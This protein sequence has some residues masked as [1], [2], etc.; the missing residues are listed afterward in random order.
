[1]K[2]NALRFV[3]MLTLL[4]VCRAR[5][6]WIQELLGETGQRGGVA[7]WIGEG[8]PEA[9]TRAGRWS[10]HALRVDAGGVATPP[11]AAP[12]ISVARVP[13]L[14]RLPYPDHFAN[15]VIADTRAGHGLHPDELVRVTAPGGHTVLLRDGQRQVL[16]KPFPETMDGWPHWDY[17]AGANAVNRDAYLGLADGLR[18]TAGPSVVGGHEGDIGYRADGGRVVTVERGWMDQIHRGVR[19][20][21]ERLVARDGF[22]GALLWQIPLPENLRGFPNRVSVVMAGGRVITP[23][24]PGEAPVALDAATGEVLV[25]Y[26]EG[27]LLPLRATDG[28][29]WRAHPQVH[30]IQRVVNGRILQAGGRQV[31][32]LDLESGRRH[33]RWEAEDPVVWMASDGQRVL[34]VTSPDGPRE[35][36]GGFGFRVD[37]LWMLD[38]ETGRA[39]WQNRDFAGRGS[40]RL[41]FADGALY[42]PHFRLARE[43]DQVRGVQVPVGS[44]LPGYRQDWLVTS[45]DPATG[46]RRWQTSGER[47][48]A[49]HYQI[50]FARGEELFV[51][52]GEGFAV[53]TRDGSDLPSVHFGPFDGCAEP[54]A[55][56][57]WLFYTMSFTEFDA[58]R[59]RNAARNR[60]RGFARSTCDTGVFPVFGSVLTTPSHC[61]CND[62]P[63][64]YNAFAVMADP[65]PVP[66]DWRWQ[67]NPA[68]PA[69]RPP[70]VWPAPGDWPIHLGNAARTITAR[71]EA[72][73]NLNLLWRADAPSPLPEGP[74]SRDWISSET[75]EG[76]I[77]PA[78]ADGNRVYV[79]EPDQLRLVARDARTGQKVWELHTGARVDSPPTLW[80]DLLFFGSRDGW[81]HAV[82]AGDGMWVWRFHAAPAIRFIGESSRVESSWPVNGSVLIHQ[83]SLFVGAGRHSSIDGGITLWRLD[84]TTGRALGRTVIETPPEMME[85]INQTNYGGNRRGL[86]LLV[87]VG[88]TLVHRREVIPLDLEAERVLTDERLPGFLRVPRQGPNPYARQYF[89][90]TRRASFGRFFSAMLS[91]PALLPDGGQTGME[92]FCIAV[93]DD[94]V[95]AGGFWRGSNVRAF[96]RD[97][98]GRARLTNNRHGP[99]GHLWE[100]QMAEWVHVDAMAASLDAHRV[101]VAMSNRELAVLD[102]RD[103]R[104]LS[105]ITL[106]ARVHRH[107]LA[108]AGGRLFATLTDGSLV[109]LGNQP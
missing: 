81:V 22:N 34:A 26:E 65:A 79:S 99:E 69:A 33:W 96:P 101:Y 89:L 52:C 32:S 21:G 97:A 14:R 37:T 40:T 1:M 8:N 48:A 43:G 49:G 35:M 12:L 10:V 98:E 54:R 105:K 91:W 55:T 82:R 15:L 73:G 53:S 78:T 107:G 23:L 76:P 30:L 67:R 4:S 50:A 88:E 39:L 106:P 92:A 24:V 51:V 90:N 11:P 102:S 62:Y 17:D 60:P 74:V 72:P 47:R 77:T 31:V 86:D 103:G 100:Y 2:Q 56:P 13:S 64:G 58:T 87:G 75:R 9:L 36:R 109:A 5:G 66:E 41:F 20:G 83:G 38:L 95:I 16:Q 18:W 70:A 84:P 59:Q 46:A 44:I 45:L 93:M 19:T 42:V 63:T 68:A 28:A 108:L 94:S 25:R 61:G 3:T 29:S 85:S 71:G 80:G 7:V 104:E 6:E 27:I 57:N